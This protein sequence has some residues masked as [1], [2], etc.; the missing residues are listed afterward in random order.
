MGSIL[1]PRGARTMG[2]NDTRSLRGLGMALAV[3]LLLLTNLQ[4]ALFPHLSQRYPV[5]DPDSVNPFHQFGSTIAL[6]YSLPCLDQFM[7]HLQRPVD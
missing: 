4:G 1:Y 3:L 2:M 7:L 6:C 5:G